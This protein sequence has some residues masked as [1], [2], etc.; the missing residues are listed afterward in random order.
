VDEV[1]GV[2]AG[3]EPPPQLNSI[4]PKNTKKTLLINNPPD[5]LIRYHFLYE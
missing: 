2:A 4:N 3:E 5:T 1:E